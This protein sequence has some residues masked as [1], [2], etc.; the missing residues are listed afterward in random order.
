MTVTT[1][2]ASPLDAL[3]QDLQAAQPRCHNLG[4]Q[5]GSIYILRTGPF[6]DERLQPVLQRYDKQVH[7]TYEFSLHPE[8]WR[9][10]G[11]PPPDSTVSEKFSQRQGELVTIRAR[12]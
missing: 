8:Q 5:N 1:E 9:K 10:Y 2:T 7:V 11:L 12:E 6:D 4:R 3:F